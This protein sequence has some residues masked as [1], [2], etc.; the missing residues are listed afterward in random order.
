MA[1][2]WSLIDEKRAL[3]KVMRARREALD[4]A[5]RLRG[6]RAVAERLGELPE[7]AAARAVS[8]YVS[9]RGELDPSRALAAV[10]ARGGVVA[11]P[12]V[13]SER[14]RLRFHPVNDEATL[15]VGAFGIFEPAADSPEIPLEELDV[16]LVPGL[17]FDEEGR[18]LGYGGGY[19]DEVAERLHARKGRRGIL[20]GVAFDFQLVARCPAGDGDVAIDCVVTDA[21]VVRCGRET[22]RK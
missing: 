3:R 2:V 6:S 18:R 8:G 9:T 7:L 13:C 19:Y 14:P 4:P 12:R 1:E 11:Y 17:A 22:E 10:A 15:A 20:V 16:V 5:D 21:R